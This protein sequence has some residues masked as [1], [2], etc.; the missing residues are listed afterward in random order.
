M[1]RMKPRKA[2]YSSAP[3][4]QPRK[5]GTGMGG[6]NIDARPS[7]SERKGHLVQ[8]GKPKG[9]LK[10]LLDTPRRVDIE[11][12]LDALAKERADSDAFL[13]AMTEGEE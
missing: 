6:V 3:R 5:W 1:T 2:D 4:M 9:K 13:R 10:E 11:P 8:E 7:R 12:E